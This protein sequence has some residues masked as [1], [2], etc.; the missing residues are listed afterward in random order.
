V[1]VLVCGA[2]ASCAASRYSYVRVNMTAA[3]RKRSCLRATSV[4]SGSPRLIVK[5]WICCPFIKERSRHD[6]VMNLPQNSSTVP[7]RRS[8]A[9]SPS[10]VSI[11]DG[12]KR[13]LISRVKSGH[14]GTP[15]LSS[16]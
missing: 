5:S 2:V 12:P 4:R 6:N 8:R 3:S 16:K 9:S 11:I 7:I 10:G 13:L 1:E 14:G 15:L